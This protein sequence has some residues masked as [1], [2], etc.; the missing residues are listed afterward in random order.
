M[1]RL[2]VIVQCALIALLGACAFLEGALFVRRRARALLLLMRVRG[3]VF[4]VIMGAV[5][6]TAIVASVK[7][8][9]TSTNM[10]GSRVPRDRNAGNL[11]GQITDADITNGWRE[12]AMREGCEIVGREAFDLTQI[13]M[14]WLLRGGFEDAMRIP[15]VGWSFPWRDGTLQGITVL[16]KCELRPIIRTRYFP[17]PFDVPLAMVPSFN[18]HLLPGGVSNVFWH[19]VSPSNS[20]VVTWE[21][22]P[23]NRDANTVTNFQA[24]LF[25]DGGFEYRYDDRT[26]GYAPVFPFDWDGDGLEN[27]VDPEPLVAGPDAHGTN[28]EWHNVVCADIVNTNAYYFVEV[29]ASRGPAPIYFNADR[30]SFLGSPIVIAR[31][32]ETNLVPLLMGVEYSATSTVPFSVYVPSNATAT[33]T[34]I[35]DGRSFSVQWPLSFYLSPETGG[36]AVDV[37][38]FDPGGDFSWTP[39]SYGSSS[40][41]LLSGT[42]CSFAANGSWIG[43]TGCGNCD[44]GGCSL[45]GTYALEGASFT[46]PSLWCGCTAHGQGG[47]N[48]P[49]ATAAVSVNFDKAVV[50]YEDAYTNAPNDVVA[51]RSTSTTLSISAY[52]GESGG[53][54]LLTAQNIN[55]LNRTNGPAIQFPYLAMIPAGGMV[56]FAMEYEA[57]RHSDAIDDIIVNAAF[58]PSLQETVTDSAS[59]TVIR[60][61]LIATA[62][63]PSNNKRHT[64]GVRESILCQSEPQLPHSCWSDSSNTGEFIQW[65]NQLYFTCPIEAAENCLTIRTSSNDYTPRISIIEPAGIMAASPQA[66]DFGFPEGIAGGVG[67]R[68]RLYIKPFNVSFTGIAIE[69]VPSTIGSHSGYFDDSLWQNDWYHTTEHGAGD[70]TNVK[71]GNYFI[72]DDAS[73]GKICNPPWSDGN[74][75]WRIPIG[76]NESNTA[77]GTPP[78]K[79]C[80]VEYSQL[81]GISDTGTLGIMKFHHAVSRGTNSVITLN[82][83][84]VQ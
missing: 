54:L 43:F 69:E 12:V 19:A 8:E 21:N 75:S 76:W 82:G 56:S 9:A 3:V 45:D 81:F 35:Y 14:P 29:V 70:W 68:M 27:S 26:V 7:P 61:Q 59:T 18:W 2:L 74:I 31:G 33:V 46:M 50:F 42:P 72:T 10:V 23:V 67:L 65:S 17:P 73:F 78:V 64:Y 83:E 40:P 52:G 20:L 79:T 41:R 5:M 39:T 4:A 62:T 84:V 63:V 60:V 13:H 57:A 47:T 1:T 11:L 58:T 80:N 49:P 44:C 15:A 28:A 53:M 6:A 24:E 77:N 25:A 37:Q 55:R 30:G 36:Y 32:G 66:I 34:G 22:S 51:R 48:E 16:S 71:P 38:P